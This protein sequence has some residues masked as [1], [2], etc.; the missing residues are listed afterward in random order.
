[1]TRTASI[2]TLIAA[3]ALLLVHPAGA[4]QAPGPQAFKGV[5]T[6]LLD[7]G[8]VKLRLVLHVDAAE[9]GALT[10]TMDSPDQGANGIP[11]TSVTV[12]G[13]TLRFAIAP[14]SAVFE[15]TLSADGSRLEGTFTQ[16][17]AR[18]PLTV[19]RGEAPP[20]PE[21]PQVPEPP[22]PYRVEDVRVQN[23]N[24]GVTLA[25]TLTLPPGPGPFPGVALVSGSGPQDR[26]EALMGHKP[27][28]VLAD[29]LTREGIAVL[30]Y[31]DRGVGGSTGTFATA[32][33]EDFTSDALAAVAFL[34]G[35][36]DIG[37]VGIV[38][39]SEGGLVGPMA[40]ARSTD[41]DFVVMLAGPG[42]PGDEILYLQGA[43][44]ARAGGA[45][46]EAV[47]ANQD[48]QERIF[49]IVRAEP[50]SAAA[51]AKLSAALDEIV[52][53]LP[54]ETRRRMGDEVSPQALRAQASQVNTPWFRFFLTYDPRPTLER[55]RVP[56][57]ALNGSLDLQ[58][59]A[60]ANL[61]EI[62]AALARGG[63]RD[64][65]ARALPGLNHLFQTATTGAPTEYATITETMSPVALQAVSGW[66]KERFA[67]GR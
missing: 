49:A 24:G 66:I 53:A 55:V 40:A 18:L 9:G 26:D 59:P 35:R 6:G 63:N 20:P 42:I 56:V 7:A 19:T 21:R 12:D 3:T 16:G 25:G 37:A 28:L 67:A 54:E 45:S 52:A 15:G 27:F 2:P 48:V 44:I 64:A 39:H 62:A 34:Q 4:Q 65:T 47:A 23:A 8:A 51:S 58:V 36:D 29:H 17:P 31:D 13:S 43:L 57:L 38:G 41:V 22:F 33:S 61:R 46:E 32:T 11:A 60:E 30:R 14:L 1:M 10:G 5:W 50:D